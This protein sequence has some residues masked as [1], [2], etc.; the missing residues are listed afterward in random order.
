MRGGLVNVNRIGI[1]SKAV[2]ACASSP[3][4]RTRSSQSQQQHPY[5]ILSAIRL[6]SIKVVSLFGLF[7]TKSEIPRSSFHHG[8]RPPRHAF[9]CSFSLPGTQEAGLELY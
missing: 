6:S 4:A 5:R 8:P 9:T 1:S 2:D 7:G 3:I